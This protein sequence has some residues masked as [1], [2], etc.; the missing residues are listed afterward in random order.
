MLVLQVVTSLLVENVRLHFI[1][2]LM[3]FG[4]RELLRNMALKIIDMG[5]VLSLCW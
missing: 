2:L 1:V 4:K 5:S 3:G